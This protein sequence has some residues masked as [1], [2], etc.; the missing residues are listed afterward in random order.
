[1]MR[2]YL[3]MHRGDMHTL[4]HYVTWYVSVHLYT[5]EEDFADLQILGIMGFET[6][7][8]LRSR[9]EVILEGPQIHGFIHL[10][11]ILANCKSAKSEV[12]FFTRA[13]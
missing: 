8:S 9:N 12:F 11:E 5:N 10:R 13:R 3:L 4:L 6:S 2:A 7:Q 1:M